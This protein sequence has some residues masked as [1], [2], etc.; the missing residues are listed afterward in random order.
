[1]SIHCL[2][3]P[4][5]IKNSN[6]SDFHR[7]TGLL[8]H[9][10][11]RKEKNKTSIAS[12][13]LVSNSKLAYISLKYSVYPLF[14][15]NFLLRHPMFEIFELLIVK[16]IYVSYIF[17]NGKFLWRVRKMWKGACQ[18]KGGWPTKYKNLNRAFFE[19]VEP[20]FF[21]LMLYFTS[22]FTITAYYYHSFYVKR[23]ISWLKMNAA[24]WVVNAFIILILHY[25]GWHL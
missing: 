3:L 20:L 6:F 24:R 11:K 12:K 16:I 23:N 1:M 10:F 4:I 7:H 19:D 17:F 25:A 2:T 5:I 13:K 22:E 18:H 15:A 14:R 8:W 9:S 21:E